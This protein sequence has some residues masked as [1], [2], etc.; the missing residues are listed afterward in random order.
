M[1]QIQSYKDITVAEL[2]K[3]AEM[4]DIDLNSVAASR[5]LVSIFYGDPDT[6]S[7][8][9]FWNCYWEITAILY[10]KPEPQP[11]DSFVLDGVEYKVREFAETDTR[12]YTDFSDLSKQNPQQNLPLLL[13]LS[14]TD[15]SDET[16]YTEAIQARAEK[17]NQLDAETALNA[18]NFILSVWQTLMR[19]ILDCLGSQADE[20]TKKKVE[21]LRKAWVDLGGK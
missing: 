9:D 21:E 3:V 19:S 18:L 7:V 14:F 15:G 11:I 20:A 5:Q 16:N 13:A 8:E 2:V 12:T 6:M 10:Q 17:F 1:R 4:K